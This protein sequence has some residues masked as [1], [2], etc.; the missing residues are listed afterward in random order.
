MIL[1]LQHQSESAQLGLHLFN[2]QAGRSLEGQIIYD[3][4]IPEALIS[5]KV[6]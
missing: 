5:Y 1:Q 2:R 6:K 4:V 3:L